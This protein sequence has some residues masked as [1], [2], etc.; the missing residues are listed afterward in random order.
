MCAPPLRQH[1]HRRHDAGRREPPR[2]VP[3][4][5]SGD[6]FTFGSYDYLW[7]A[8]V[9][10]RGY[11]ERWAANVTA[12]LR[13]PLGR[14]ASWTTPTRRCSTTTTSSGS[15][16]TRPTPPTA[17][18]PARALA[19]IG[20]RLSAPASSSSRTSAPGAA[21]AAR[22][23][24]L[25]YVSGGMEEQFTKWGN[26]PA[27][28][29]LHR[30]RL[31]RPACRPQG[32]AGGRQDLLGVSHSL[33]RRR[34]R[35]PLRLGDDA[36]GGRRQGDLRAARRLHRETW[37]PEYDYDLGAPK[38]A[39]VQGRRGVTGAR[40]SAAL[41]LVN[42]TKRAAPSASAAATAA[43]AWRAAAP[44]W[45][46]T[47]AWS[48]SRR[49][50]PRAAGSTGPPHTRAA[51]RP[52]AARARRA[53][54]RRVASVPARAHHRRSSAP[55]VGVA[56]SAAARSPSRRSVAPCVGR[57]WAPRAARPLE[58]AG[59]ACASASRVRVALSSAYSAS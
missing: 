37:F 35:G 58:L 18:R 3:A 40:S 8:D 22:S 19:V 14:R 29:L 39:R 24:W 49:A 53:A 43:R 46:P 56:W 21:T 54:G 2:V 59:G 11:Q 55:R 1:R 7:A 50:R 47:P 31:G 16:S 9:G 6:R 32:D 30:R 44:R 25:K 45:A 12:E 52:P 33:A 23:A 42:P 13:P 20:P 41:V 27:D 28:R 4:N 51:A 36:A 38:G 15:P 57:A 48:S 34:R 5:T 10:N 26:D 17:P